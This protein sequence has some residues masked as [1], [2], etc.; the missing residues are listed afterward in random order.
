[1]NQDVNSSV[2]I[3]FRHL[4]A[5]V[6]SALI[7]LAVPGCGYT[8]GPGHD[9]QIMTVEVPT[10]KN[11]T[12]RR[13]IE[14]QLT[15]AVQKE[16]QQ[17]TFIRLAKGAEAQ[18]RL[19]GT[20]KRVQKLPRGQTQFADPRQLEF[21]VQVEVTWEDLST[22]E[23]ISEHTVP[24]DAE[25]VSLFTSTTFA[26]EVGQSLATAIHENVTQTAS[27]IVDMMDSPW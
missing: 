20:I 24:F 19:T 21:S 5:A 3:H 26:P 10:F 18:T 22:G 25:T 11:E 1:M 13:G 2:R 15:E 9:P 12:F 16:I 27:Q 4:R 8:V 7:A 17:R 14:Q 6:T 23:V